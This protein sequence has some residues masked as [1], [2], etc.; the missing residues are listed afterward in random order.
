[1]A[2]N[3]LEGEEEGNLKV[4]FPHSDSALSTF[5]FLVLSSLPPPIEQVNKNAGG[6]SFL[7]AAMRLPLHLCQS[8]DPPR[9]PVH[10]G[11]RNRGEPEPK[12]VE[13]PGVAAANEDKSKLEV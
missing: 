10:G 11:K 5:L 1:M 12:T 9:V 8:P 13:P 3:Y 6:A 7:S 4:L 2:K